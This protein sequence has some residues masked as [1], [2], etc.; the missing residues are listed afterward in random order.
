MYRALHLTIARLFADQLQADAAVLNSGRDLNKVSMAAKWTPSSEEFHD[1]HTWIVGSIAELLHPRHIICPQVEKDDRKK[2]LMYARMSYRSVTVSPLRKHLRVVERDITAGTFDSINY[3]R[4]PSLAMENYQGIFFK[5][6]EDRFNGYLDKVASGKAKISGA[7]LL[8]SRMVHKARTIAGRPGEKKKS[9]AQV[10]AQERVLEG[11]WKSL[12]K[13]MKNSG[14]IQGAIGV[15]DVSSSMSFKQ[16]RDGTTPMDSAIGL[17]L[18]LAEVVDG[19]FGGHFISFHCD[20]R[21][22]EVGGPSDS[23]SFREKVEAV[24][25]APWG[26]NTDF[27]AVFEKLILPVA[28][29]NKIK[30]EDMIK[31]V[32]VFSDMQFDEASQGVSPSSGMEV[33]K[34]SSSFE[35]INKLYLDAG[36]EMPTL[37]F[38][39]LAGDQGK[40]VT[41]E[42][43]GTALVSGCSQGQL[44]MFLDGGK[45]DKLEEVTVVEDADM[46]ELA[47]DYDDLDVGMVNIRVTKKQKV[48][49]LVTVMRAISHPAYAMLKVID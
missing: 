43:P 2:Y 10:N 29:E 14:S 20:P 21:L 27:I 5:K 19:P 22:L 8:P 1:R 49:P 41:T 32:F 16:F 13:R 45:F 23:R 15:C 34:W 17:S 25:S 30:P 46:A 31:Q 26:L 40:P 35:R 7:I 33:P 6:D 39:N 48:D 37:V 38:W 12:V 42:E 44:K 9:A 24:R 28:I 4:V 47:G 11:Q 18:L 3:E 36:Y